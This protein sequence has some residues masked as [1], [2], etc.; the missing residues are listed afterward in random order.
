MNLPELSNL[1]DEVFDD[2]IQ[3]ERMNSS[4]NRDGSISFGQVAD[5]V[6]GGHTLYPIN[7]GV[8]IHL[9]HRILATW[10]VTCPS[11]V[12]GFVGDL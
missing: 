10:D 7:E 8:S 4:I 2:F 3:V 12:L 5:W 11:S 9:R 1:V 6:K